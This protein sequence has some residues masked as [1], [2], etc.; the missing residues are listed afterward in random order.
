MTS[1]LERVVVTGAGGRLGSALVAE[2]GSRD[3]ARAVP[4]RRPEYDL[5]SAEP[6]RLIDR[7]HPSLVIHAAAWTDVDGC[8][9]EPA[10]AMRR[11][12]EAGTALSAA[13]VAR[14]IPL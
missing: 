5:D 14:G 12:A 2:L 7:D 13:C 8:A 9:R 11:N 1:L 4:W 3:G 10:L 6:T